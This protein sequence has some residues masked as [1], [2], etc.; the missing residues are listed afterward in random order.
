MLF[1]VVRIQGKIVSPRVSPKHRIVIRS[2]PSFDP[3]E[4]I[5]EKFG[6]KNQMNSTNLKF[7]FKSV[8]LAVIDDD[9]NTKKKLQSQVKVYLKL[10]S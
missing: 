9:N 7:L 10:V 3:S 2:T 4:E 5:L 8:G 6:D 1:S